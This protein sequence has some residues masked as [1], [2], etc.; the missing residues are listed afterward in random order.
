MFFPD[1]SQGFREVFR[2]L[3]AS[4]AFVF[5]VWDDLQHNEFA[6]VV[7]RTLEQVFPRDPP[8]FLVRIPHG[9]HDSDEIQRELLAAGF[10]QA[11]IETL[12]G[13]S[14]CTSPRD[15]AL[16][17]CQ[18]TPLHNEI[19]ARDPSRME[20]AVRRATEALASRF[21]NGPI[22]GRIRALIVIATR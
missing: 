11:K 8:R 1:R 16:G 20:E 5:N 22:E 7:T 15:A 12:D 4:G 17:Y 19:V 9:Y 14:R 6:E 10:T 21:G 13:M 18:G 3:R 2:V